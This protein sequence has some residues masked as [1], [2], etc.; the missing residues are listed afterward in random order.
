MSE[1]KLPL[2]LLR[3]SRT[4][5]VLGTL[6]VAGLIAVSPDVQKDVVRYLLMRGSAG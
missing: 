4:Q 2:V 1:H 6:V 5:V 3:S